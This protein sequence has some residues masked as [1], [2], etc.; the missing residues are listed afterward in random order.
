M[1]S[2]DTRNATAL[3]VFKSNIQFG[4]T[5]VP[6][7]LSKCYVFS[8]P[9]LCSLLF[10]LAMLRRSCDAREKL[11]LEITSSFRLGFHQSNNDNENNNFFLRRAITFNAL[12]WQAHRLRRRPNSTWKWIRASCKVGYL[13]NLA[14]CFVLYRI[15]T[16]TRR[17]SLQLAFTM[18]LCLLS[19][20]LAVPVAA[21]IPSFT[22]MAPTRA[23]PLSA[24]EVRNLALFW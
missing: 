6:K 19:T 7:I 4:P 3:D 24:G 21:F 15:R 22:R 10:F 1:Y 18:K 9:L 23:S 5:N 14:S 13:Q 17:A 11:L 8:I 2:Y 12:I 20:L 16:S